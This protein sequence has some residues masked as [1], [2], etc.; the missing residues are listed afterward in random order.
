MRV[1]FKLSFQQDMCTLSVIL[2]YFNRHVRAAV[3]SF[4]S[5]AT[6]VLDEMA[7]SKNFDPPSSALLACPLLEL[8]LGSLTVNDA[9]LWHFSTCVE[10]CACTSNRMCCACN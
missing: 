4:I 10:G 8:K 9:N 6:Y 7:V 3:T 5:I 1:T 2:H